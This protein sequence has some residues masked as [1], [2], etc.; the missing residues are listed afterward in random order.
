MNIPD[1]AKVYGSHINA[2][3]KEIRKLCR[4]TSTSPGVTITQGNNGTQISIRPQDSARLTL[5]VV[6]IEQP[7]SDGMIA[8]KELKATVSATAAMSSFDAYLFRNGQSCPLSA[9]SISLGMTTI[10]VFD[11]STFSGVTFHDVELKKMPSGDEK[12]CVTQPMY[13]KTSPC[14]VAE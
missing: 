13:I 8:V 4:I 10:G 14:E 5:T 11:G 3:V 6:P 2:L 9:L 1:T 7:R 12:Y